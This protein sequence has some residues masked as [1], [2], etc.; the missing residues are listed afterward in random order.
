MDEFERNFRERAEIGASVSIWW[1]GDEVLSLADGWME[2]E[3]RREW[4]AETLVPVYSATKAPA[5]AT[6]LMVLETR[7]MGV[8]TPVREVWE[9]FP[10]EGATFGDL[11]SHQ[12]GL[13]ALDR[14]ASVWDH[15]D[16]VA[17]LEAQVPAWALGDGHGYHPRTYGF[18][19]DEIVRRVSGATFGAYWRTMIADPLGLEFWIGLPE[20][21]WPRVARLYPGK[22]DKS[23]LANPFYKALHTPG[24]L[25]HKAFG[26]PRGLHSVAEMNEPKAWAAEFP[27]MGGIGTARALARF[28]QVVIGAIP[29]PLSAAVRHALATR[30]V[31]GDDRVLCERTSFSCAC[32]LDPLDGAG[33]KIRWNYGPNHAAFGHPG[34][35]GSHGF[36]D[37]ATGISFAYA[38]NRMELSVLPGNKTLDM[39]RALYS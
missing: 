9:R 28:Y 5:A 3:R 2:K 35:G 37:P 36:G 38:M 6:V 34:A 32:Q 16:V 24:S 19:L 4:R 30:R 15:A 11:L 26:S 21:E 31:D 22:A 7:G 29:G 23:G 14:Q 10:V 25:T 12:C 8:E 1:N 20:R 39:V 13:A 27:A 33:D 18:L 17:A